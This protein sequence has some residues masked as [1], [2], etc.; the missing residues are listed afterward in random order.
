MSLSREERDKKILE[1][2]LS[3]KLTVEIAKDFGLTKQRIIQ[4]AKAQG[5]P[6]RAYEAFE[7]DVGWIQCCVEGCSETVRSRWGT[8]CN[9]H[10]SRGRRTGTTEERRRAGPKITSH[11]YM[12]E[13]WK[14]HPASSKKGLLYE[15]RKVFYEEF[16]P[17]NHVCKWCGDSLE[18]GGG[19]K[20]KLHVDH[21]NGE[22]VDNRPENLVASCHRCNVNRGL[23]MSWL[24]QHADDPVIRAIFEA[25]QV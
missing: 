14:A 8:Y 25:Y 6:S 17:D 15:H 12:A 21:L 7:G 9:T 1:E 3:G 13:H 10:Y 22:K 5:A 16:G 2:Y 20:G 11:G 24:S 4:V 18:W 23:F 19:G